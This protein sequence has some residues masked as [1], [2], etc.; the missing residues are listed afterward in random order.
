MKKAQ[1]G[2]RNPVAKS[3]SSSRH[4]TPKNT[5]HKSVASKPA[6]RKSTA[7]KLPAAN[8]RRIF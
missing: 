2:K 3:S 7:P 8:R 1:S 6:A 5:A 4:D